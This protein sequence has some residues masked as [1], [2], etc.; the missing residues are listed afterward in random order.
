MDPPVSPRVLY[1]PL[2][3]GAWPSSGSLLPLFFLFFLILILIIIFLI[4]AILVFRKVSEGRNQTAMGWGF[5]RDEF[6]F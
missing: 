4:Q 3:P 6:L 2:P 1:L 5:L